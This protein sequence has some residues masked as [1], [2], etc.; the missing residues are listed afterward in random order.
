VSTQPDLA[1]LRASC[2][3]AAPS[4]LGWNFPEL[5]DLL[6]H[7][8]LRE[9]AV[10]I[11]LV[12]RAAGWHVLLTQR[13]ESLS[14]HAGQVSFP[15]G[16]LETNE[17]AV[18]AAIRECEEEVGIR[19]DQID[20]IGYQPRFATISAYVIT[21]VVAILSPTIAPSPQ[22]SEVASIFEAPLELFIDSRYHQP[23]SR[24]YK[25]RVRSTTVIPY[26]GYRIWG[27]T[28]SMMLKWMQSLQAS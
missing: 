13:T 2:L 21:P 8:P 22:Q 4:G 16:R 28:A 24:E 14:Q 18:A 7:Q 20:V 26:Q 15:G 3:Q 6:E 9:A 1:Q 12:P 27:A 17:S 23:E 5:A 10:L 25:G 11:G 19:A